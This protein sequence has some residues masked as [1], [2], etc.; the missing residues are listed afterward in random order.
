[1]EDLYFSEGFQFLAE[2]LPSDDFAYPPSQAG[3]EAAQDH[4]G[5]FEYSNIT[6]TLRFGSRF[7]WITDAPILLLFAPGKYRVEFSFE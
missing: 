7:C 5:E 1:M 4:K 6:T 2:N 3:L